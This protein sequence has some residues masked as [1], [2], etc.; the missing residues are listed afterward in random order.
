MHLYGVCTMRGGEENQS[1]IFSCLF[2]IY[3]AS[4]SIVTLQFAF[5]IIV[6]ITNA[7]RVVYNGACN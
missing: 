1:G 7:C 3:V 2:M 4:Y 5:Y 6:I